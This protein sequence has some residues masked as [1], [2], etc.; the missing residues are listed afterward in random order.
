ME[1]SDVIVR[2]TVDLNK[3]ETFPKGFANKDK[4]D[5]TSEVQIKLQEKEDDDQARFDALSINA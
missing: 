5:A 4:L 1:K 3:P 2:I